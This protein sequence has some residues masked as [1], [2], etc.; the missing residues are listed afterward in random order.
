MKI[1]R[2]ITI[3]IL[4]SV[5]TSITN[6]TP[7]P[8]EESAWVKDLPKSIADNPT[9]WLTSPNYITWAEGARVLCGPKE[10]PYFGI[11]AT[12]AQNVFD[13]HNISGDGSRRSYLLQNP[14]STER[15]WLHGC[16]QDRG[17]HRVTAPSVQFFY[18]N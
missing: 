12:G 10:S 18:L 13:I 1:S 2:F 3:N 5:G 14:A 6:P 7:I 16:I 9:R 8:I 17:I 4:F 11:V 15:R